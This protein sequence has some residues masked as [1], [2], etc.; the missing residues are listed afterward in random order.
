L[1]PNVFVSDDPRNYRQDDES[2]DVVN[3]QF[4]DDAHLFAGR[5][6]WIFHNAAL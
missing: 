5:D 1:R 3:L 2:M 6:A 4:P